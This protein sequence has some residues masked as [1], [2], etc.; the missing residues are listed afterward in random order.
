M[1]KVFV[2][3]L[4]RL[5][6][7]LLTIFVI[8]TI[9]FVLMKAAPG[10]PFM[11]EQGMPDECL[12]A[13][14]TYY[15]LEDPLYVQYMRYIGEIFT[16]NFGPSLKYPSQS[17]N[18]IIREGFPVSCTLGVLALCIA[19]PSGMIIG[20]VAAIKRNSSFD[21]A[22]HILCV[23]GLSIPSFVLAAS[24]QFLF[25]ICFSFFPVA[26]WGSFM[27]MPLPAFALAV[28]PMCMIIKLFR[29]SILEVLQQQY[30]HTAKIKGLS[31]R[32][33]LTIHIWKNAALPIITYLGPVTANILVGSFIVERV[34]GIPGLG[35]WFVN[36]VL[37]RDYSVIGGL[38]IF[39]SIIL[40]GVHTVIDLLYAVLDPRIDIFHS[41]SS[42]VKVD[43]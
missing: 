43:S 25:A 38:T 9:T 4:R 17:V 21:F 28:G 37:N 14:R 11:D 10:D 29:A 35:Q 15:G 23:F 7:S 33:I 6:F 12:V 13:L 8:A 31:N 42:V 41:K 39:Y 32:R 19:I 40:L 36:G 1:K 30:I 34:F 24:L 16:F 18:Q 26:R 20:T 3:L 27:H 22:S 2:F 5:L